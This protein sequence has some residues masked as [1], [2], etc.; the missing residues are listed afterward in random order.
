MLRTAV[1]AVL[2]V[3][4]FL[5]SAVQAQT[6]L[7]ENFSAGVG[8][9]PPAGW[10]TSTSGSSPAPW[11]FDNPGARVFDPPFMAPFAV[12]DSDQPGSTTA[13]VSTITSPAFNVSGTSI[14]N[15]VFDQQ[16]R[17]LS[18]GWSIEV[19]D[20][21]VWNVVAAQ[22]N[23]T[24]NISIG[25]GFVPNVVTTTHD[26]TAASG[27]SASAQVRWVYTYGWDWWWGIDNVKVVQPITVNLAMASIDAPVADPTSCIPVTGTH[28]LSVTIENQGA[29][30]VLANTLLQLDYSVNGG[31]PTTDFVLLAADLQPGAFLPHTFMTPVNL[32]APGPNTVTATVTLLGD[33][34]PGDDSLSQA[35]EGVGAA[36]MVATFPYLETFDSLTSNGT[37]T[38]PA[39][40]F[41]DQ[42]DA[43]GAGAD[44]FFRS[45]P[46][47]NPLS[48]P[49]GDHSSG[50]GYYAYVTDSANH[51]TVSLV[52]P[53]FDLSIL[54]SPQLRFWLY[55]ANATNPT[56]TNEN[57]LAIDVISYPGGTVISNVAGPIGH[58]GTNWSVQFANLTPFVGQTV[59][60]VFRGQSD[61]GGSN[62]DIAIDDVAVYDPQPTPGQAPQPGLAVLDIN[63][64]TN[65]NASIVPLGAAG[66]YYKTVQIGSV[67][68]MQLS[69]EANAPIVLLAG[70][71][72]PVAATYPGIGQLDIGGAVNPST[73]LPTTIFIIGDGF[74]AATSLFNAF[75]NTGPA[76]TTQIGLQIPNFPPGPLTT[77]QAVMA[78][79]NGSLVAISNAVDVTIN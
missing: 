63:Q 40:W 48:G 7:T 41:Q 46:A 58:Q 11:R 73:G 67:M 14:V 17:D 51:N 69:G 70:P 38:P 15:L 37:T 2:V 26:I 55:S 3:V 53:C 32:P 64:S 23:N 50:T 13:G 57:F 34:F 49:A 76:A 10:M 56:T 79:T 47:A 9:T 24:T 61:G 28:P 77:F 39:G 29:L 60:L 1:I 6:Y 62:H 25:Y 45:G 68:G 5:A 27:G 31:P 52:S 75:F 36:G 71:L 35:Y 19:F 74:N 21:V 33:L 65:I 43:T 78:T 42:T 66:P 44:W 20:G 8:T 12:S 16:L 54:S 72:T 18:S 4:S 30:P 59:Q 22:A